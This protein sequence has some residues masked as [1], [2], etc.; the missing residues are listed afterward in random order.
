MQVAQNMVRPITEPNDWCNHH[1]ADG[2]MHHSE[3][4]IAAVAD[5]IEPITEMRDFLRQ[6]VDT[7]GAKRG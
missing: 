5:L 6:L 3:A 2:E 4:I 1:T 7:M